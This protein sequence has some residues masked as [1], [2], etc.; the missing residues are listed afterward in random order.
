MKKAE[1]ALAPAGF[2][3]ETNFEAHELGLI[4]YKISI[5]ELPRDLGLG[6]KNLF[7]TNKES[8]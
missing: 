7:N 1:F 2:W 4:G 5:G 6:G 3:L 8:Y